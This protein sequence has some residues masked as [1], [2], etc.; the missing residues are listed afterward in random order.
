MAAS[1]DVFRTVFRFMVR[2]HLDRAYIS[3]VDEQ[4]K[5]NDASAETRQLI[6]NVREFHGMR[7]HLIQCVYEA[8]GGDSIAAQ[9]PSC[10]GLQQFSSVPSKST[11]AI[12]G[13]SI[14]GSQGILLILH[15]HDGKLVPY[16]VHARFK[17]LLNSVWFLVHVPKEIM[18]SVKPWLEH[19]TWWRNKAIADYRQ[20]VERIVSHGDEAFVKRCYVK[21]KEVGTNIQSDQRLVANPIK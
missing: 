21:I 2:S 11:C 8:L 7:S 12:S 10:S 15:R 13:K 17:R 20:V 18:M 14:S 5:N 9:F 6:H 4:L 3:H 16:T 1:Y 19:Q